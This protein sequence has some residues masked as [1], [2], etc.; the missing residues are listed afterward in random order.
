MKDSQ[1]AGFSISIPTNSGVYFF[2]A[3]EIIRMEASSNY[4]CI[5]FTNRAPLVMAKIL[6]DYEA[7]LAAHGFVRTHRSH[8]VNK[9]HIR[10][11]DGAGNIVMRDTSRAEIARRK[12]KEVM[13]ALFSSPHRNHLAA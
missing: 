5:Y 6:G 13:K 2:H 12:K 7:M 9:N 10:F 11:I 3:E 1:T 8:L 4:T